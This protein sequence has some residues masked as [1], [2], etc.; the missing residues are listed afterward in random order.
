[1]CPRWSRP[2]VA[3]R[4][5]ETAASIPDAVIAATAMPGSVLSAKHGRHELSCWQLH[6][7]AGLCT[8]AQLCTPA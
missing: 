7:E 6:V 8:T 4:F 5:S 2:T 1:M 3:N